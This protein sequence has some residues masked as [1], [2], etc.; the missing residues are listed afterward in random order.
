MNARKL[1]CE[2]RIYHAVPFEPAL[3]AKGLRHDIHSEMGL[4]AGSMPGMAF[5]P[6]GL[7]FDAQALG[8]KSLAQFFHDEILRLHPAAL[9]KPKQQGQPRRP[10]Y[11]P[12][13]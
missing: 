2:R 11:G 8:R 7:V 12:G 9:A 13:P 3:P 5:V 6:V 1:A 4:A 10:R